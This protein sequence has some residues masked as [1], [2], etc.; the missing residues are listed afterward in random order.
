MSDAKGGRWTVAA[1]ALVGASG[2][3]LARVPARRAFWFGWIA[4]YPDTVLIR[5]KATVS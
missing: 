4:Q 5:R 1:D 3:R 2:E